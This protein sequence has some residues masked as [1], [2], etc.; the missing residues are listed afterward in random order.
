MPT[1]PSNFHT[2][3]TQIL[4]A[5]IR[6][7]WIQSA[8]ALPV[9]K[10]P[11]LAPESAPHSG[12]QPT[13]GWQPQRAVGSVAHEQEGGHGH[14][15]EDEF[16]VLFT[17]FAPFKELFPV[18]PSWEIVNS[19][20]DRLPHLPAKSAAHLAAA[21]S[22]LGKKFPVVRIYKHPDPIRVNYRVVYD[23][24]P[25]LW[26]GSGGKATA[27]AAKELEMQALDGDTT[28]T[29]I[30]SSNT[31]ANT[32]NTGFGPAGPG[33]ANTVPNSPP[34]FTSSTTTDGFAPPLPPSK[35]IDL[36]VHIGMAGPNPHYSLERLGHRTGYTTRDVDGRLPSTSH[37]PVPPYAEDLPLEIRTDFDA[38]D[39]LK[40]WR[41]AV[42]DRADVRMSEDAGRYLC[43]YIYY[44]S[45][46]LLYEKGE[47]RRVVF[48]H[49]PSGS[50]GYEV[51]LGKEVALGLVRAVVESEVARKQEG[52][53][54]ETEIGQV[55][56][57]KPGE[58]DQGQ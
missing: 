24:V 28:T 42:P 43:D 34:P 36:V 26:D 17:G 54:R 6:F 9:P 47:K 1:S 25:K 21:G 8:L 15:G 14:D 35:P 33:P 7:C 45:L 3:T 55:V 22:D 16:T 53:L 18:N 2:V 44:R 40:R 29:L 41:A 31:P 23:L 30:A 57:K 10:M 19:L 38:G 51:S 13:P 48:L 11:S 37:P 32:S 12:D 46:E 5:Y 56:M 49:V 58:E 20:P 39:I 52:T 50:G 4:V 27:A